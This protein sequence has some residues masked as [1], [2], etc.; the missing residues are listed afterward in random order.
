MFCNSVHVRGVDGTNPVEVAKATQEGRRRCQQLAQFMRSD[1]TGF[2]KA[3]MA[4]LSSTIGG[5]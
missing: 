3:H 2:D 4:L 5:R 1:V